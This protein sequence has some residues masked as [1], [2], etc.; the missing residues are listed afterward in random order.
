MQ[1]AHLYIRH[2]C[3]YYRC[4]NMFV[5]RMLE[6]NVSTIDLTSYYKTR[7]INIIYNAQTVDTTI[8]IRVFINNNNNKSILK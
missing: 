4:Y 5:P 1:L 7:E 6:I 8:N 2:L 3:V